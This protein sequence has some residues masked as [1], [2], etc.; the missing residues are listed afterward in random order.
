MLVQLIIAA[1]FLASCCID[2]S[3]WQRLSAKDA[4]NKVGVANL[5][6]DFIVSSSNDQRDSD[7]VVYLDSQSESKH[8]DNLRLCLSANAIAQLQERGVINPAK[9]L[10][11]KHLHIAGAVMR[12]QGQ[13]MLPIQ[14]ADQI[15]VVA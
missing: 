7:G 5:D 8:Q 14:S 3:A 12:I 9:S 6:I 4:S 11:G 10:L 1:L 15:T 13:A 2:V